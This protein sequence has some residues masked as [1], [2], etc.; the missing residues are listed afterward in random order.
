MFWQVI[1]GSGMPTP[2]AYHY[3]L[4]GTE[5]T[6]AKGNS[7]TFS[8]L[9]AST[10]YTIKVVVYDRVGNLTEQSITP[11]TAKVTIAD[12]KGGE[13]FDKTTI[14]EDSNGKAV[15]VPKDFKIT[16]DSANNVEDGVVIEDKNGNQFVWIPVNSSEEFA[17][18]TSFANRNEFSNLR[19]TG[20]GYPVRIRWS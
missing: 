14:I 11:T 15:K 9:N 16:S 20:G 7:Y 10:K 12:K 6:D 13:A 18:D 19:D 1:H 4:N 3:Y 2:N 17:I 8:A 5:K